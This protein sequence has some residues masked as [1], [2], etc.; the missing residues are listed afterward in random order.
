LGGLSQSA[1]A[2]YSRYADDL[3]FSG[4]EVFSNSCER[5]LLRV[6]AIVR[7]EGFVVNHRKTRV[8]HQSQRQTLAGLVA[9]FRLNVPRED[10]DRL[11]AILTNCARH[12]A[13]GQNRLGQAEFR[14]HLE[15][16]VSF[17]EMVNPAKGERLRTLFER[18]E[19]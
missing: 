3:A 14:S 15:G 16:R 11:K 1:G 13:A 12:G 19:W 18:I 7:E 9:N 5:F 6:A 17:V 10:F 8:M 4:G 2:K